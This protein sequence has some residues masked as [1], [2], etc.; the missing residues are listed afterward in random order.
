MKL[1]EIRDWTEEYEEAEERDFTVDYESE[2]GGKKDGNEQ[3][4]VHRGLLLFKYTSDKGARHSTEKA[5]NKA[6]YFRN[7][8]NRQKTTQK[9]V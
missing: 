6:K 5:Y 2:I 9:D 8:L 3:E 7:I 1:H 4:T